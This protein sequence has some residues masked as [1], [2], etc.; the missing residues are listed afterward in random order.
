LFFELKVVLACETQGLVKRERRLRGAD[1][2]TNEHY[3]RREMNAH[4]SSPDSFESTCKNNLA[5]IRLVSH[6]RV[7]SAVIESP[8]YGAGP[9][10]VVAVAAIW[11]SPAT[12]QPL[13]VTF[14]KVVIFLLVA[15]NEGMI[16]FAAYPDS[17]QCRRLECNHQ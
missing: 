8:Q 3:D 4:S 7:M 2:G 17:A 15:R 5:A 16:R 14:A 6:A 13:R 12:F 1:A 9:A 11:L 10:R